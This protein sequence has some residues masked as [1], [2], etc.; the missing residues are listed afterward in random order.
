MISGTICKVIG[1][2]EEVWC[3][4]LAGLEDLLLAWKF[5]MRPYD[6]ERFCRRTQFAPT[7]TSSLASKDIDLC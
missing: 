1:N 2:S 5:G 7:G 3:L 6:G 4:L